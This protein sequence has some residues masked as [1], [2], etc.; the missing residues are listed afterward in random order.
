MQPRLGS[1]APASDDRLP[2]AIGGGNPLTSRH[3]DRL[4]ARVRVTASTMSCSQPSGEAL[5]LAQV[6]ARPNLR[7]GPAKAGGTP[8][9]QMVLVEAARKASRH[10]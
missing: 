4:L 2:P 3:C 9:A 10:Q 6:A 7:S 5:M 1:I 8:D